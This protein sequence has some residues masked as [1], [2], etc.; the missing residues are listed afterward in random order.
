MARRKRGQ[1]GEVAKLATSLVQVRIGN[2]VFD[3]VYQPSC[4][5]CTHPAR[6]MIEE[7]LVQGHSY[8]KI[9]D[10]FSEKEIE[11]DEGRREL[12]PKIGYMSIRNHFISGHLPMEKAALRRLSERRAEQIGQSVVDGVDQLVDG[13]TL[14]EAVVARTYERL[15]TGII[16]PEV[17]DGLAAAKFL[18]EIE[19]RK[20]G[21][22]DAEAWSQAMTRY[23]ENARMLMP[24][25]MWQQ[26]TMALAADPILKALQK[27]LDPDPEDEDIIDAEVV[28]GDS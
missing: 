22:F 15:A 5:T 21:G 16:E 23:F 12:M 10:F 8:R 20:L 1:G 6:M 18:Q 2:T 9:A 13:Y 4:H 7:R 11:V 25:A 24:P 27:R 28:R 19:D 17:K 26:F 14:S 3:S